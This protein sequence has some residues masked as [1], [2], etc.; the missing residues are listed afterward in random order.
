MRAWALAVIL[1]AA[2]SVTANAAAQSRG[3]MDQQRTPAQYSQ[4]DSHPVRIVGY[5]LS[6]LG[7]AL[8]YTIARPL[9]YLATQ[10]FLQPILDPG[11]EQESWEE[12]YG[13]GTLPP[14]PPVQP[15]ADLL[16]QSSPPP[17]V[18]PPAG[19]GAASRLPVPPTAAQPILH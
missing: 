14:L 19:K 9:H 8:E 11:F 3:D 17:A 13:P 7:V 12:F 18:A 2:L 10:T 4:E 6:P 15:R 16:P 1:A 5:I